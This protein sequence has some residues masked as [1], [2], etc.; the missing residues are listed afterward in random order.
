M[1][2]RLKFTISVYALIFLSISYVCRSHDLYDP[3]SPTGGVTVNGYIQKPGIFY[4]L[5]EELRWRDRDF[6]FYN[7]VMSVIATTFTNL[8][9]HIEKNEHGL[10]LHYSREVA[11]LAKKGEVINTI[12]K[13]F[14][15]V[16]GS[17][18]ELKIYEEQLKPMCKSYRSEIASSPIVSIVSHSISSLNAHNYLIPFIPAEVLDPV[19]KKFL[20]EV[21]KFLW[22][23]SFAEMS[24]GFITMIEKLEKLCKRI[25]LNLLESCNEYMQQARRYLIDLIKNHE[26][27]LKYSKIK[28]ANYLEFSNVLR[29]LRGEILSFKPY[30]IVLRKL[31]PIKADALGIP[32][33]SGFNHRIEN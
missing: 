11:R 18:D 19:M 23:Q 16:K 1:K 26:E 22:P 14:L 27:F 3:R 20:V 17:R 28:D 10:M 4:F 30:Q 2:S 5:H 15:T 8:V 9:D 25:N 33:F 24:N 13:G 6:P 12:Y 32:M 21:T 7:M 31:D 29:K